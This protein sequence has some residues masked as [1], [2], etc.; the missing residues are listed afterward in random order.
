VGRNIPGKKSLSELRWTLL[1][2]PEKYATSNLPSG[3][4]YHVI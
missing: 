1:K 2:S 4:Q 3:S